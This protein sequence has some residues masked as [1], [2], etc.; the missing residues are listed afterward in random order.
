MMETKTKEEFYVIATI[1]C[2]KFGQYSFDYME[3]KD[4]AWVQTMDIR[5]AKKYYSENNARTGLKDI[6]SQTFIV[7][8]D[9]KELEKL[10][11]NYQIVHVLEEHTFKSVVEESENKE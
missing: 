3:Q 6:L 9:N 10:C 7:P 1:V 4:G 5:F 2:D 8:A 11:K